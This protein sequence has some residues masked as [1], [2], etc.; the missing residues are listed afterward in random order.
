MPLPRLRPLGFGEI[1]DD[2]F[3]LYRR[4]FTTFFATALVCVIP[5]TLISR[6]FEGAMISPQL[7]TPAEAAALLLLVPVT[8]LL[9]SVLW[10]ALTQETA[11][12]YEG[13]QPALKRAYGRALRALP[14][15]VAAWILMALLGTVLMI[16]V[17]IVAAIAVIPAAA[18]GGDDGGAVFGAAVGLLAVGVM[19]LALTSLFALFPVIVIERLGPWSGMKRSHMLA[20]G[21][22]LRIAGIVLVTFLI[23]LLPTIGLMAAAGMGA[24]MWDIT[25]AATL[26]PIQRFVQQFVTILASAL[27][28]PFMVGCFT[29]LYFDR[30]VRVEGYDLEA[31]TE[32]LATSGTS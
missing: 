20:K 26:S 25:A 13:G 24:A 2:A 5:A 9:W 1:L 23:V 17:G 15:I 12:A 27:T 8:M 14:A 31:A 16:V 22:R 29:L 28:T 32:A 10:G 4:N 18:L 11:E 30:R 21:G 3:T 19:L 6:A 7:A